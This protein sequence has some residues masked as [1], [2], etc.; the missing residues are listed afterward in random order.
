[1]SGPIGRLHL[2]TVQAQEAHDLA[3]LRKIKTSWK[4]YL[5]TALGSE[6]ERSKRELADCLYAI[7]EITGRDT[8]RREALAAYREYVLHA[9]A[10]GADART[11]SRMRHLEDV[12]SD[13][14]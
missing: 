1:V 5:R 4:A 7:Q 3:A 8:D 10:G 6:R 11:V 9:P 14:Q 13:S 2:A 12:L